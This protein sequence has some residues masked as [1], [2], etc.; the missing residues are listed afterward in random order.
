MPID[1]FRTSISIPG[2]SPS[3][4]EKEGSLNGRSVQ[5]QSAEANAGIKSCR[6][7]L[8]SIGLSDSEHE[9]KI[10][11]VFNEFES[12][13]ISYTAENILAIA[14]SALFGSYNRVVLSKLSAALKSPN[15]D[16]ARKDELA[17]ALATLA[18]GDN[19]EAR[20]YILVIKQ[21]SAALTNPDIAPAKKDELAGALA[22]LAQR[23]D[24][25]PRRYIVF[26]EHLSAALTNPDIAPAKKDELAGALATLAQ[27]DKLDSEPRSYET[28]FVEII[29][30]M[31]NQSLNISTKGELENVFIGLVQ[32]T[33]LKGHGL[34]YFLRASCG[35]LSSKDINDSTRDMLLKAFSALTQ[36]DA[37][38]KIV[39][40]PLI[41]GLSEVLCYEDGNPS[42]KG[43]LSILFLGLAQRTGLDAGEVKALQESFSEVLR[44]ENVDVSIKNEFVTVLLEMVRKTDSDM[45]NIK[46]F[47]MPLSIV[48]ES[49]YADVSIKRKIATLFMDLPKQ[50]DLDADNMD[51]FLWYLSRALE[52]KY[53]DISIKDEFASVLL[54]FTERIGL[55]LNSTPSRISCLFS[56]LESKYVDVSIKDEMEKL[57]MKFLRQK[58][59]KPEVINSFNLPQEDKTRLIFELAVTNPTDVLSYINSFNLP[60][61]DKTQLIFKLSVNNSTDVLIH[62]NDII[63]SPEDKTRLVVELAVNNPTN[64]LT[65]LND[66]ILSPDNKFQILSNI[67]KSNPKVVLTKL[68]DID[69]SDDKKVLLFSIILSNLSP[70][71][72]SSYNIN[73]SQAALSLIKENNFLKLL[74]KSGINPGDLIISIDKACSEASMIDDNITALLQRL[75]SDRPENTLFLETDNELISCFSLE[76]ALKPISLSLEQQAIILCSILKELTSKAIPRP[77]RGLP[78]QI[79]AYLENAASAQPMKL[80]LIIKKMII[81]SVS[82]QETDPLYNLDLSTQTITDE[83]IQPE[84]GVIFKNLDSTSLSGSNIRV[85]KRERVGGGT[86][87]QI[88]FKVSHRTRANLEATIKSLEEDAETR[89]ILSSM[90]IIVAVDSSVKY[91]YEAPDENGKFKPVFLDVGRAVE[92]NFKDLG[93]VVIGTEKPPYLLRNCISIQME[94]GLKQGESARRLHIISSLLGLGPITLQADADIS[95]KRKTAMLF[96]TFYPREAYIMEQ[97][98]SWSSMT[99]EEMRRSII[100]KV[101]EMQSNFDS[102]Y[103]NIVEREVLGGYS[104]FAFSDMANLAYKAGARMLM[105][106]CKEIDGAVSSIVTGTLSLQNRNDS[107][108]VSKGTC[109]QIDYKYGGAGHVFTRVITDRFIR[110][111]TS[112]KEIV[113]GGEVQLIYDLDTLKFSGSTYSYNADAHGDKGGV[114]Q[115]RLNLMEQIAQIESKLNSCDYIHNEVLIKNAIAPSHAKGALVQNIATKKSLIAALRSAKSIKILDGVE[116]IN[117]IPVDDFIHVGDCFT[118]EMVPPLTEGSLS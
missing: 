52:S 48:L 61:E 41:K 32:R 39:L 74:D 6:E 38:C 72:I 99:S 26:I 8:L 20:R 28:F 113:L 23:D 82:F 86:F 35:I 15:I 24:L 46:N 67:L 73:L 19:L 11:R 104:D 97:Q 106:G 34:F 49:K 87:H 93:R 33:V 30:V 70:E 55:D 105:R 5:K 88:D 47:L 109:I 89:E 10:D 12:Q 13:N 64:V 4:V 2:V 62:L 44:S 65:H 98:P 117:G 36:Q 75:D 110:Q 51:K 90:G 43:A 103:G 54:G 92:I 76:S 40:K 108:F 29:S 37:L 59:L 84:M 80:K 111:K 31:S 69:I 68:K 3:K 83:Q 77:Q 100:K 96:R 94:S 16:A 42:V 1:P 115:K 78:S 114:Y 85:V 81:E 107:G 91:Q 45:N 7:L 79:I 57:L 63:L 53:V 71:L 66:I 27:R 14:L 22:T 25:G 116:C 56:V 18:Q 21:L 17:S 9:T 112:V 102:Y 58:D 60:Q 101:P 95:E 118:A 50:K